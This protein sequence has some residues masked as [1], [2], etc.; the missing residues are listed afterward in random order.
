M[1][2]DKKGAGVLATPATAGITETQAHILAA[3]HAEEKR[4]A[5][6]AAQFALAGHAL[7]K[8]QPGRGSAPLYATR[9]GLIKPLASLD[10]A[11]R[12]L[13]EIGGAQ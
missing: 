2:A 12:F 8:T 1:A 9:W 6:L 7:I 5:M 4:F 3:Q 10:A 13:R 11:A